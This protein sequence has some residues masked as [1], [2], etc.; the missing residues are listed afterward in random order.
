MRRIR[1]KTFLFLAAVTGLSL[2]VTIILSRTLVVTDETRLISS[3]WVGG[4][5][6][7]FFNVAYLF[8]LSLVHPFLKAPVMSETYVRDF[9]K[10]ALVYPIRNEEH[11][12]YERIDYSL[13]GNQLPGLDLWVLS[14]SDAQYEASEEKLIQRLKVKYGARVYYRRRPLPLERKQGNLKDFILKHPEYAY[15]YIVDADG[16][17]PEGTVLKLLRKAQHPENQDIAIFQCLIRIAHA[18]TWYARFEK[19]GTIFSQRFNFTAVQALFGRSISFGH[20]QLVRREVLQK[21]QLPKG[22][23]SHDNW[24]T[25][26]LDQMGYRVVFCPDAHAFDE[27]PSN[28]LEA[29]ERSRR[30]AHGTLQGWPLLLKRKVS[31]ESR[32]LCFY[33]IY[34]YV[35]D[36]VFFFWVILG[37]LSHSALTGE[38]IHFQIDSIWM[39][40]FTNDF[41]KWVLLGSLGVVFFH[42]LVIVRNLQDFRAY[43]YELLFSTLVTLNNFLYA[44]FGIFAL[45]LRK[46]RWRPMRKNPFEKMSFWNAAKNLWPGTAL[47]LAGLYFLTHETPYFVWQT[48]PIL[49]S[50]IGSIPSVY[51]TAKCI[52]KGFAAWI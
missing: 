13:E 22:L 18:R 42:K 28:Y 2:L 33:G 4:F 17:V 34:L 23:L 36:I 11:G 1:I 31:P 19:V 46:L 38:L 45:P 8:S 5:A 7:L 21:I 51:L 35:A 49:I 9:P 20:H 48:T 25:V 43:L 6:F 16:M 37:L 14:D 47:G 10:V 27:A 30:W 39:G 52:P 50:L 40:A 44:P 29:K 32:F 24:D 3:V 12:L 15:L 26:L 41:A